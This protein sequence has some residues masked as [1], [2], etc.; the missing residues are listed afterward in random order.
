MRREAAALA[1]LPG[2]GRQEWDGIATLSHLTSSVHATGQIHGGSYMRRVM[3]LVALMAVGFTS[4]AAASPAAAHAGT[5]AMRST[6]I[7]GE[8]SPGFTRCHISYQTYPSGT[9]GLRASMAGTF[10]ASVLGNLDKLQGSGTVWDLKE[11]GYRARVW[12]DVFYDCWCVDNAYHVPGPQ[13]P[14]GTNHWGTTRIF[15]SHTSSGTPYSWDWTNW[16]GYT[17]TYYTV[18]V[19]VGRYQKSTQTFH[20]AEEQRFYL[21]MG[22][23]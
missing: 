4:V 22:G 1:A 9:T 18:R 19:I 6:T 5:A 23:N 15:D 8:E 16:N 7:C 3:S 12:L 17:G 2:T 21:T 20:M 14:D 13:L 10:T 11:D